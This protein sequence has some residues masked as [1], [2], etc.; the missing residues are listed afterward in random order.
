MANSMPATPRVY[1]MPNGADGCGMRAL[2]PLRVPASEVS[3]DID[4]VIERIV[5]VASG[6]TT[7]HPSPTASPRSPS[8]KGEEGGSF[9]QPEPASG[10]FSHGV[11]HFPIRVYFEDTDLSGIVYH[12]NYLRYMERAR[13]DMLRLAGIDQ[14]AAFE[15]GEGVYAVADLRIAY[16]RPA[17]L[18]DVLIIQSRVTRVRAAATQIEQLIVRGGET[19]TKALVTAALVAPEGRPMRQPESWREAF[20]GL[21]KQAEGDHAG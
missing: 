5:E 8:P 11:H 19:V 16:R 12:A 20:T 2:R 18:D 7:G 15:A 14:R 9:V 4:H 6:R 10:V 3:R 17:R 1:T 13:S 21:M